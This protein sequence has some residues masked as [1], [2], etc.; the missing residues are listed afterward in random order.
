MRDF[1]ECVAREYFARRREEEGEAEVEVEHDEEEFRK[2]EVYEFELMDDEDDEDDEGDDEEFGSAINIGGNMSTF[3][4]PPLQVCVDDCVEDDSSE[5]QNQ[6]QDQPQPLSESSSTLTSNAPQTQTQP[7][8]QH[9]N[10][11]VYIQRPILPLPPP[12]LCIFRSWALRLLNLDGV[13]SFTTGTDGDNKT[14]TQGVG[15]GSRRGGTPVVKSRR[16]AWVG[17]AVEE[18]AKAPLMKPVD[19]C[20]SS[21]PAT[22]P[23]TTTS[24]PLSST[25]PHTHRTVHPKRRSIYTRERIVL[26]VDA[27]PV[28]GRGGVPWMLPLARRPCLRLGWGSGE[29]QRGGEGEGRSEEE[30]NLNSNLRYSWEGVADA[31][32]A[33][34]WLGGDVRC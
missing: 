11:L 4:V 25:H 8:T 28:L 1:T 24:T 34:R 14:N 19:R 31:L 29:R 22:T 13:E 3:Y 2:E 17:G 10:P 20:V 5:L 16:D 15:E 32:D 27:P 26:D 6:C 33:V 23:P 9:S 7:E 30:V 18:T 12:R 21:V